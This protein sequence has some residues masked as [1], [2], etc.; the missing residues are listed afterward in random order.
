LKLL[1]TSYA[2][3]PEYIDPERWLHRIRGYTGILEELAKEH[4]VIAIERINYEGELFKNGVRYI[5]Q[6]QLRTLYFPLPQ[7]SLIRSLKPDAVFVNGFIF[8]LQILQLR[9][10]IGANTRLIV[11][12]RAEKPYKGIKGWLQRKADGAVDAYLFSSMDF[13]NDWKQ[14][15]A[16]NKIHEVIQGS[17]VFSMED[18]E[19]ARQATGVT[20]EPAFLW[21]GRLDA[22]KDPLTILKAFAKY[23][24]TN[25]HARLYMIYQTEELLNEVKEFILSNNLNEI[26]FLIGKVPHE[27]LEEWYNAADFILSGSH[28]E[29]GGTVISEAMSCGCIPIVT[30]IHSFKKMT[31]GK[32]GFLFE[33]GNEHALAEILMTTS[34]LDMDAEREKVLK[35]F[36]DEL[37]FAAI[38]RKINKLLT[39]L[40]PGKTHVPH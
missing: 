35:Q 9:K 26:I 28:Y 10:V 14:T 20:G 11:L 7:H 13:A 16:I 36:N 21:V 23:A 17:S 5:F 37:S 24:A 30:A 3:T 27:G 19:A 38:G 4:E 32:A 12:H 22:N 40:N 29:G 25:P 33:A 31:N 6:R 39:T 18:R 2:S 34:S 8:P 1:F 15:I